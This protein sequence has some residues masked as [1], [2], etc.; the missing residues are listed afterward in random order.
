MWCYTYYAMGRILGESDSADTSFNNTYVYDAFGQLIREN[1]KSLDKT[2]VFK[3]NK[4]GNI[5]G[6]DA[7][8]YTT[9]NVSNDSVVTHV[10]DSTIK[11]RLIKFNNISISYDANGCPTYYNGRS[12]AWNKGKLSR[13]YRG[14]PSQ[15]GTA[16][17]T[18][19]L[20][21]GWY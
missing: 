13:I 10:Y 9:E 8:A 15:G 1:N 7:L 14:S 6:C 5:I 20:L 21:S 17:V 19:G 3:Y 18:S 4:I 11:D 12:Y 2:F 16:S